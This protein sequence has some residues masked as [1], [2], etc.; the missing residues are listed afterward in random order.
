M[1]RLRI[2]KVVYSRLVE[3]IFIISQNVKWIQD[4]VLRTFSAYEFRATENFKNMCIMSLRPLRTTLIY[5]VD[6]KL[7]SNA[8]LSSVHF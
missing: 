5:Q 2:R 7:K 1:V 8:L 4:Q 3:Y 6:S